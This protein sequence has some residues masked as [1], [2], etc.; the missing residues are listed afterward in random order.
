MQ[1]SPDNALDISKAIIAAYGSLASML[2][3][4]SEEHEKKLDLPQHIWSFLHSLS[5]IFSS[6][7]KPENIRTPVISNSASLFT[8]LH[9]QMAD[10]RQEHFRVLFLSS[11]NMLIEDKVMWKGTVDKVQVH[12]REIIAEAIQNGASAIITIHNH[13]WGDARPSAGDKKIF[14]HIEYA[15][16]ILGITVHDHLIVAPNGCYSDMNAKA[17]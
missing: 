4:L 10:L 5:A 1:V 16:Q 8:Y 17:A 6:S 12:P 7:L 11:S 15:C 14:R 3:Q 2:Q 13:P 9:Q